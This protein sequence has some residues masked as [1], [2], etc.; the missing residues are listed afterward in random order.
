MNLGDLDLPLSTLSMFWREVPSSLAS[1]ET[2]QPCANRKDFVRSAS[3]IMLGFV[4][5]ANSERLNVCHKG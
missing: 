2:D 4:I 3:E 1:F 5:L